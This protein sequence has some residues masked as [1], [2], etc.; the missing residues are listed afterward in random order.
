VDVDPKKDRHWH[1]RYFF[2]S[3][4]FGQVSQFTVMSAEE[5]G[6]IV[7]TE[8]IQEVAVEEY[9]EEEKRFGQEFIQAIKDGDLVSLI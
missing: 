7:D 5:Q 4:F 8:E 3:F 1:Y 6:H 9:T 2:I